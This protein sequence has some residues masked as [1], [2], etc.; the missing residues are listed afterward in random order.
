[1]MRS[2]VF[3]AIL[4]IMIAKGIPHLTGKSERDV[5]AER[6]R[7]NQIDIELAVKGMP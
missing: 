4:S 6:Y 3:I 7:Q 5:I 2:V 1:M